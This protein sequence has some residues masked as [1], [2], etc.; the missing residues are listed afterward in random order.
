MASKCVDGQLAR[1]PAPFDAIRIERRA[2]IG[3]QTGRL[4]KGRA[5]MAR[6]W[7][8]VGDATTHGGTVVSGS[9]FTG[10]DGKPVARISDSVACPKCGPTT[11]TSGDATIVIDGQPVARHGDATTCGAT[12]IAG[13][14]ARA[15]IL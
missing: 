11:I 4:G 2:R 10:I 6:T 12:L 14:Q 3:Y 13:K 1:W 5:A 8:V 15:F 9:P 7:I